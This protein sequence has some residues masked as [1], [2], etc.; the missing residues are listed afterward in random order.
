MIASSTSAQVIKMNI[1]TYIQILGGFFFSKMATFSLQDKDPDDISCVCGLVV[2]EI[3]GI[4]L[5]VVDEDRRKVERE[6]ASECD[7]QDLLEAREKIFGLAKEKVLR[8]MDDESVSKLFGDDDKN[9]THDRQDLLKSYVGQ[10][11]MVP[12][13]VEH[14]I[15]GDIMDLLY[16]VLD[17]DAIFPGK[18][19]KEASLNKGTLSDKGRDQALAEQ[20]T[21]DVGNKEN[22]TTS[23]VITTKG[24]SQL[25]TVSVTPND[26]GTPRESTTR[27]T[28]TAKPASD[29]QDAN[30]PDLTICVRCRNREERKGKGVDRATS[31]KDLPQSDKVIESSTGAVKT[32]KSMASQTDE[33]KP[34]LRTE[35][36]YHSDYIERKV[37]ESER[38]VN[39]LSRWRNGAQGRIKENGQTGRR[40][41]EGLKDLAAKQCVQADDFDRYKKGIEAKFT[42]MSKMMENKIRAAVRLEKNV[43]SD[44]IHADNMAS[45][46]NGDESV[47]DIPDEQSYPE[48]REQGNRRTGEYDAEPL[49]Q[50]QQTSTQRPSTRGRPNVS[51][52]NPTRGK[53]RQPIPMKTVDKR[54]TT[55]K[56]YKLDIEVVDSDS[57]DVTCT[58]S[59][60]SEQEAPD[61]KRRRREGHSAEGRSYGGDKD[62][63][64]HSNT[65][66]MM[67]AIVE[68][69]DW[70]DDGEHQDDGPWSDIAEETDGCYSTDAPD[71]AYTGV[72]PPTGTHDAGLVEVRGSGVQTATGESWCLEPT[73]TTTKHVVSRMM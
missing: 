48:D 49:K 43:P 67:P 20:F 34:V 40:N 62:N 31:T 50:R 24:A 35:F 10:W 22:K 26:T 15:S 73:N 52:Q 70:S 63:T 23:E 54:V 55:Q 19:L 33:E 29:E 38:K 61:G 56:S 69:H 8:C 71:P 6:L 53:L 2:P 18:L 47:W 12:R 72:L 39:K 41:A 59:S 30:E 5:S 64:G 13:H 25:C 1:H 36:D 51:D 45:Y 42:A 65:D 28:P 44:D 17:R 7:K 58:M 21:R 3:E 16:F 60:G 32:F 57:D 27:S 11:R 68:E 4:L 9:V 46:E 37:G 14:K 66:Q